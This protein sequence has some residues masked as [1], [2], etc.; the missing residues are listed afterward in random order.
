[1]MLRNTIRI[2]L[3]LAATSAFA[4]MNGTVA[5][6][7]DT[8]QNTRPSVL[9]QVGIDQNLGEQLPLDARFKDESGKDVVL[10]DFFQSKRPVLLAIV[11]YDCPMLCTQVLNGMTSAIG[12]MKFTAGKEF[13]VVAVSIDP[14]E[15]PEIAAAKKKTYI[16]RYRRDGAEQAFHF[17]TGQQPAITSVTKAAGFRYV[18]DEKTQQYAHQSALILVTP[19]G[20]VAQY[21]YGI[22][23][24]PKDM[25]LGMIEASKEHIGNMADQVVLFCYHYD[26]TTGKYGAMLMNV[27][28]AGGALTVMLLVGFMFISIRKENH[29]GGQRA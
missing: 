5:S 22:E 21:Y 23:Y 6:S 19:D 7:A 14:R 15:T 1:M 28:R 4:Q 27:V 3:L 8:Q 12:V 18:W 25:R 13:D 9:Q 17:L 2:A 11:Y 20:K 26:P 10:G 24:S 16:Q 29:S